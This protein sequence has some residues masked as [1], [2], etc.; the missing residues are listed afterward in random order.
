MYI[1][2]SGM[3]T[4]LIENSPSWTSEAILHHKDHFKTKLAPKK[5]YPGGLPPPDK[6][7]VEASYLAYRCTRW[8]HRSAMEKMMV[9]SRNP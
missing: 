7:M 4:G 8:V 6:A 5:G 3:V 9:T 2:W 1:T